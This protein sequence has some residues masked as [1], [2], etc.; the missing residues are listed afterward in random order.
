MV[1]LNT[2]LS[3]AA[4]ARDMRLFIDFVFFFAVIIRLFYTQ[5]I[6]SDH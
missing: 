6:L 2:F 1:V 3:A 5:A 4:L